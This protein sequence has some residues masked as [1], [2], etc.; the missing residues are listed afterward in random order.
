MRRVL[1]VF[2]LTMIFAVSLSAQGTFATV[3]RDAEGAEYGRDLVQTPDGGFAQIGMSRS[4]GSTNGI[5]L[6]KYDSE[7]YYCE[8]DSQSMFMMDH[9]IMFE[10]V[11]V[12]VNTSPLVLETLTPEIVTLSRRD[13]LLC[14][15]LDV[16]ETALPQA[17]ALT[18]FPNPFNSAVSITAPAGAEIEIFD[19]SGRR[20]DVI[21]SF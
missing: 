18:V 7:G 17:T 3:I 20:I 10:P 2:V 12:D 16:E 19:V 8:P 4:Y 9:S 5:L 15:S 1:F 14:I 13:S 21:A 11:M 6:I